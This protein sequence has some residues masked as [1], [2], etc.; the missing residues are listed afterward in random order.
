MNFPHINTRAVRDYLLGTLSDEEALAIEERYFV[1]PRSFQEIREEE[2]R[3]IC[4]YLDGAL[5]PNDL[6]R[7]EGRYLKVNQLRQLVEEV[8]TRRSTPAAPAPRWL[9]GAALVAVLGCIVLFAL[10]LVRHET[11]T[12]QQ[13]S[14]GAQ[15]VIHLFLQPI[16]K[17]GP[18]SRTTEF[19][20]PPSGQPIMLTAD[21]PGELNS[22]DYIPQISNVDRPRDR[23]I[24]WTG[25]PVRSLPVKGGQQVNVMVPSSS[26]LEP[27]GD[28]ILELKLPDGQVRETYLFRVT[29][30][31]R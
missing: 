28:Y 19:A 4:D 27:G 7:F 6:K 23:A 11:R 16:L 30:P 2:L 14:S 31:A 3:L 24:V 22:I 9:V 12:V 18:E 29:A 5:P 8:R 17:K 20:L 15:P 26:Y 10:V 13:A 1:N 25:Q 21:V